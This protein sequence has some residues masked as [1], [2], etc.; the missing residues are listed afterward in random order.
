MREFVLKVGQ[1]QRRVGAVGRVEGDIGAVALTTLL[2][3]DNDGTVGG[4]A[5]VEGSGVS[6]LQ[7]ADALDVIGVNVLRAVARVKTTRDL[8]TGR[9][10]AVE[11]GDP[12]DNPQRV[13]VTG[14]RVDAADQDLGRPTEV[15]ALLADLYAGNLSL[16]GV[17]DVG[18][19]YGTYLVTRNGGHGVAE[20]ALLALNALGG[21]DHLV[22]A[23]GGFE[24]RDVVHFLTRN[25]GYFQRLET[26]VGNGQGL[27]AGGQVEAKVAVDV[28]YRTGCRTVDQHRGSDEGNTLGIGD[29]TGDGL[30]L[31]GG[32]AADQQDHK[33]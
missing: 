17:D 23:G 22:E 11:D 4:A 2:G 33:Q 24:H 25:D 13:V 15:T 28:G 27:R 29:R 8:A 12:I 20:V 3:G 31:Q 19:P 18:F 1:A 32:Q 10:V 14:Q 6:A 21:H 7:Y 5:T 26:R 16:Q 9:D 30:C